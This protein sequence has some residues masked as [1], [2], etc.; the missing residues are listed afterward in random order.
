MAPTLSPK[1]SNWRKTGSK[2]L[3]GLE[4]EGGGGVEREQAA[5]LG[6]RIPRL[7]FTDITVVPYPL[8]FWECLTAH[9]EVPY[10]SVASG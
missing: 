3:G 10:C 5:P 6:H 7:V 8:P 9:V 2:T 4:G 1:I